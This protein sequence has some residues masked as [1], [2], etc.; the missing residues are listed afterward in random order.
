MEGLKKGATQG[1]WKLIER[2]G[3][4]G[5]GDVWRA[6]HEDGRMGALKLL[7]SNA[8][9][10]RVRFRSEI[11]FL[12]THE[13]GTGVLPLLDHSLPE[14]KSKP[15]WYVMPIART[16]E[17]AL[18]DAGVEERLR[19]IHKVATTLA[20]L[21]ERGT[22]HR[23]IKPDNLFEKDGEYLVGDFGLVTYPEKDPVTRAGRRLGPVDYLAP[24]MRANADTADSEPADVYSLAKTIWTLLTGAVPLPGPHRI[25]DEAYRLGTYLSHA[26]LGELDLL[27]ERCTRH[28]PG[29]RPRLREIVDELQAW[30]EPP[31]ESAI[32]DLEDIAQRVRN[33]SEPGLRTKAAEERRRAEFDRAWGEAT[34]SL[35]SLHD[36]LITVFPRLDWHGNPPAVTAFAHHRPP[37]QIQDQRTYG[38]QASNADPQPVELLL[39]VAAQWVTGDDVRWAAWI[40]IEDPY[41]GPRTLWSDAS[42]ASLGS[43]RQGQLIAELVSELASR[44]SE[45]ARATVAR[46]ELRADATRFACWT[47]EGS[48][49]GALE[50]PWSG[51]SP[52]ADGDEG[53][54]VVDSGNNRILRFGPGGRPLEWRSAGVAGTGYENL[55]FPAG[56]CFDHERYIWIADH[57]N[58]RLRRFDEH[59]GPVEGFGLSPPG[60]EILQGPA[61]VASGPDG[62]VYVADRLR[63]QLI[64]FSATGELLRQWGGTGREPGQMSVPCGIAV[65]HGR[66]IYLSDSG[67]NRIQ[68]FTSDG[69]FVLTWGSAGNAQGCFRAP[70]GIALDH[71]ENVYVADSE[72]H[73]VQQFT[74]E[75]E[76]LSSWGANGGDGTPGTAPGQFVQP[77]GISIDGVGNVYVSEF[78]GGRVQRFGPEYLAAL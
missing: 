35:S 19:A 65:R 23:D 22:G 30:L 33:L 71:E 53:C 43:A 56:G 42:A 66:F 27:L 38:L 60:P 69:E 36:R 34:Q 55:D 50:G 1:G 64:K 59:G 11:E 29:E 26:R 57:D 77:R 31:T 41:A 45:A 4:G 51:F 44:V 37:E 20:R 25:D 49:V 12:L 13:P 70:H 40:R 17:D 72:N 32:P 7:R 18:S 62:S 54:Y 74:S 21:A 78:G 47:G 46:M 58:Q 24:E 48:G 73:R 39:A 14:E 6:V 2:L 5:N 52:F 68:K 28:S 61:D 75:G 15:A 9:E 3:S 67:N 76:F 63:H 8:R 16:V 10:R